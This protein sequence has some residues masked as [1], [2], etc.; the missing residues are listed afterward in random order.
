MKMVDHCNIVRLFS[1]FYTNGDKTDELYLNLILEY[2]PLTVYRVA[3]HYAKLKQTIPILHIKLYMYQLCR[4]LAYI[5]MEGICHRDIK[6]Q[7]LLVNP[8]TGV[9]KL[10]DFGSAK[11][12]V[13]GTHLV[14][15]MGRCRDERLF[16]PG[17]F[18]TCV[19][20]GVLG[21]WAGLGG[22]MLCAS[23]EKRRSIFVLFF[24]IF[25]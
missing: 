8:E 10:C 14:V 6:P 9:L 21:G 3:R 1:H 5:H 23:D 17:F 4:A 12:L 16:L 18:L 22:L 19:L 25:L 13:R 7:N 24:C 15:Q 11:R 20:T 2:V